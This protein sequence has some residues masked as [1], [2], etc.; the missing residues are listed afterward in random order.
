LNG[1]VNMLVDIT[2]HKI[3]EAKM[4]NMVAIVQSSDDAIV[5]KTLEGIVTTWNDS[6][7]RI[8]G[9]TEDEIIG[10]SITKTLFRRIG[11]MKNITYSTDQKGERVDHFE[12]KRVSK[13][14]NP[15][16]HFTNHITGE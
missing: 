5:S 2:E 8:F 7:K 1:A 4:A 15:P 6:A 13:D 9:Y 16:R 11:K 12:T 3:I 14:G 10:Q